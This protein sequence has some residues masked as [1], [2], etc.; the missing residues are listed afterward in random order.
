MARNSRSQQQSEIVFVEYDPV[1]SSHERLNIR[2]KALAHAARISHRCRRQREREGLD[3]IKGKTGYH[4]APNVNGRRE[5]C[6]N[7]GVLQHGNSDPF[8]S[9]AVPI[10]PETTY[11]L[12]TWKLHLKGNPVPTTQWITTYELNSDFSMSS[13]FQQ[14]AV[15]FA[16]SALLSSRFGNCHDLM[17]RTLENKQACLEY[18]TCSFLSTHGRHMSGALSL[19]FIAACI[20]NDT[21]EAR[22]Y[23]CQLQRLLTEATQSGFYDSKQQLLI[24]CRVHYYDA[25]TA[26]A[27]IRPCLLP[28]GLVDCWEDYLQ[29]ARDWV[30]LRPQRTSAVAYP[31]FSQAVVSLFCRLQTHIDIQTEGIA[32]LADKTSGHGLS[33]T[34]GLYVDLA[35][36]ALSFLKECEEVLQ[37]VDDEDMSRS[38]ALAELLITTCAV[39]SLSILPE[40]GPAVRRGARVYSSLQH[41]FPHY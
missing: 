5:S 37:R 23:Y 38:A 11:C 10:T 6:A 29:P 19:I 35:G 2:S 14:K 32:A 33:A 12:S 21:R 28:N 30:R 41:V 7:L 16:C 39:V 15:L 1:A 20:N 36:R 18:L 9:M 8:D 34:L 22:I 17:I 26:L 25:E 31:R 3:D 24:Q 13:E 27:N 40:S 4:P